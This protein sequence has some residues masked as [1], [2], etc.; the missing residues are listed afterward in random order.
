GIRRE[1]GWLLDTTNPG[2]GTDFA[3]IQRTLSSYGIVLGSPS[4]PIQGLG[5]LAS[6]LAQLVRGEGVDLLTFRQSGGNRWGT[7]THIDLFSFG[8]PGVADAHLGVDFGGYIGWEYAVGFGIDT[9][10][11]YIDP[12]THLGI[13]GGVYAGISGGLR[14]LG[15]DLASASGRIS[16]DATASLSLRD[17]HN[18]DGGRIYPGQIFQSGAGLLGRRLA[19]L[20]AQSH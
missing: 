17:P 5:D 14:V 16:I 18:S 19:D 8:I 15:F 4:Q 20:Q 10:G 3:A 1:L 13:T 12:V 11:F 2:I 9:T 7:G 6:R